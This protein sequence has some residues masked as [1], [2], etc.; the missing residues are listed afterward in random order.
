MSAESKI[1]EDFVSQ[2][3]VGLVDDEA[4]VEVSSREDGNDITIDVRVAPDDTGKVIGRQG[5]TVKAIRTLARALASYQ[6][7]GQVEVEIINQ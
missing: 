7:A 4:A 1:L 3:V 2:I 6:N 5:R